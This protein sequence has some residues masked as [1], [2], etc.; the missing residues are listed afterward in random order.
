MKISLYIPKGKEKLSFIKKEISSARN[1]QDRQTRK[2]IEDG[3]NKIIANYK[4][5]Y[6][7]LWDEKELFYSEYNGKEFIYKCGKELEVPEVNTNCRYGL[8]VLDA[9]ECSIA[10]L[11]GKRIVTLWHETSNVPG[12]QDAGGQ[13]ALR[14]QRNREIALNAWYKKIANKM[15]ELWLQ[16]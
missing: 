12:K 6:F 9:N 11:R 3:L 2:S 10:E 15:K 8:I 13:S 14:F 7:Y 1:I 5:G 4:D 16:T